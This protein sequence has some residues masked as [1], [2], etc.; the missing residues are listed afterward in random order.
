[1][2]LWTLEKP[3][4]C[5]QCSFTCRNRSTLANHFKSLHE[6]RTDASVPFA[7]DVC[8]RRFRQANDLR[9]HKRTH[10]LERPYECTE[11][12]KAFA[13]ID[14]RKKH[15]RTHLRRTQSRKTQMEED[16]GDVAEDISNA[17]LNDDLLGGSVALESLEPGELVLEDN[18][19]MDATASHAPE[20][21]EDQEEK[22]RAVYLISNQT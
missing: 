6:P 2:V 3:Y 19:A 12:G 7:C 16:M 9:K 21:V 4:S 1:M 17:L 15:M 14:Y 13:R 11:C 5:A 8:P 18:G 10:T 20:T 22:R